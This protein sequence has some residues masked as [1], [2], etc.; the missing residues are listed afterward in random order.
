MISRSLM[1]WIFTWFKEIGAV[2]RRRGRSTSGSMS[3]YRMIF[4]AISIA[5][6]FSM[7]G[8]YVASVA[9]ITV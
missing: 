1:S 2:C 7:I 9:F 5:M 8:Y 6:T 3:I 4:H